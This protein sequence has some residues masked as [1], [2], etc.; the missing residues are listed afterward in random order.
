MTL[1]FIGC[2]DEIEID[3]CKMFELDQSFVNTDTTN[4]D[5]YKSDRLKRKNLIK[6]N[7]KELI[8]YSS[9][10]GF[11]EMGELSATGLDSC[12]NWAVFI[13]LFHIGQIEPQLF[14]EDE[15]V[16]LFKSE[17]EK[18]NLH[19]A[20]IFTSLREGFRGYE[21]CSS[22]EEH[23]YNALKSWKMEIEKLPKIKFKECPN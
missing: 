12:R 7:F 19:S 14:F 3:F 9:Q 17:I 5:K 18:G 23:I 20:S 16:E 6:T 13:T 22:Q 11:P 21:F 15:T 10:N 2:K 1:L 8:H 4:M